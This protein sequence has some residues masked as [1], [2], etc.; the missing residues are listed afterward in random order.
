MIQ[1]KDRPHNWTRTR[2]HTSWNN[3]CL[4]R[5]TYF[6]FYEAFGSLAF[7]IGTSEVEH[8]L[9]TQTLIQNQQKLSI[10]FNNALEKGVT[11]K[12][13]ILYVIGLIGTAGG[14]GCV[15]TQELL[16]M[17]CRWKRE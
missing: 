2:F 13:V 4:R 11:A 9:S 3:T 6:K 5:L 16:L 15:S 17:K 7:G 10:K 12:D 8:V 14:T 1:D